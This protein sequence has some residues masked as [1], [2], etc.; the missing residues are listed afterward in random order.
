VKR[1]IAALGVSAAFVAVSL[2][3]PIAGSASSP[4][5]TGFGAKVS[6]WT[7]AHPKNLS[8]C[9]AGTCFGS[10]V[11]TGGERMT[12]FILVTINGGRIVNYVQNIAD[13]TSLTSAKSQALAL[14]P[15][16][17]KTVSFSIKHA[18]GTCADWNLRSATLGKALKSYG[19]QQGD[20]GIELN[21]LLSNGEDGYNTSDINT[22]DPHPFFLTNVP[23]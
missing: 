5:I 10:F 21:T 12:Q 11:K 6:D 22:A 16:D 8:G 13:G 14:M 23:C 7:R 20:I 9:P 4:P 17:T 19:D 15:P 1:V 2:G 18:G 3:A